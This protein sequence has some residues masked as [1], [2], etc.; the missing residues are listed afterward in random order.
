M[1]AHTIFFIPYVIFIF[2]LFY[3]FFS[4]I[5]NKL[6]IYTNA[7][8]SAGEVSIMFLTYW[9]FFLAV[10]TALPFLFLIVLGIWVIRRTQEDVKGDAGGYF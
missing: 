3:S 2:G 10:V 6:I 7:Y 1:P 9:K 5:Y 4:V 8:I